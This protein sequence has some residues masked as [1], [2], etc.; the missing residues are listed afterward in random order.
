[1]KRCIFLLL[2]L[3]ALDVIWGMVWQD[4][5]IQASPKQ[6]CTLRNGI[7]DKTKPITV[8]HIWATWCPECM[9]EMPDI[10]SALQHKPDGVAVRMLSMDE[11]AEPLAA[12]Y[13]L[14]GKRLPVN[15]VCWLHDPSL[16]MVSR[17]AFLPET[18][19]YQRDGT[20]LQRIN[21]P[22]LWPDFLSS[23][24]GF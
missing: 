14:Q 13:S 16:T 9:K 12:F 15:E 4:K 10:L 11:R 7:V 22:I 2:P 8:V 20:L 21:T 3:L 24:K 6:D 5:V 19:V 23:L 1:M 18:L 17:P